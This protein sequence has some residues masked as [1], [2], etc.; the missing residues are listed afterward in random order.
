MNSFKCAHRSVGY[1]QL[2]S[3]V[4]G[5]PALVQRGI[6]ADPGLARAAVTVFAAWAVGALATRVEHAKRENGQPFTTLTH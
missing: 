6:R 4:T 1:E 3:R 2:A 5:T